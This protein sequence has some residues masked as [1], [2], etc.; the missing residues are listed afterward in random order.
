MNLPKGAQLTSIFTK[1]PK[2]SPNRYAPAATSHH[3]G[4][5]KQAHL[6]VHVTGFGAAEKDNDLS[7]YLTTKH[8]ASS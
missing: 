4:S 8:M 7:T 2:S 5:H 6:F 1:K 3:Q